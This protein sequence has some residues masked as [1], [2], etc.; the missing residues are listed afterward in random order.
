MI[1]CF[2]FQAIKDQCINVDSFVFDLILLAKCLTLRVEKYNFEI[3]VI[4]N[5]IDVE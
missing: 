4:T 1:V 5:Y 3:I 2:F